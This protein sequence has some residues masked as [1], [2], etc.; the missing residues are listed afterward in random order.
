MPLKMRSAF[1]QLVCRQ[2]GRI[3]AARH[4]DQSRGGFRHGDG[5]RQ[6]DRAPDLIGRMSAVL[7]HA[8]DSKRAPFLNARRSIPLRHDRQ[9]IAG[10]GMEYC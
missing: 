4:L 7:E 9:Q 5:Q 10:A 8:I 3:E 6:A 1:S 2:F